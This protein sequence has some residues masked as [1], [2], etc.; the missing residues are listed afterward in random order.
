M[1]RSK[2]KRGQIEK[3]ENWKKTEDNKEKNDIMS[4][5]L[6]RRRIE[7]H[8]MY[9]FRKTRP[10]G[11]FVEGPSVKKLLDMGDMNVKKQKKTVGIRS[12]SSKRGRTV[13]SYGINPDY[14]PSPKKKTCCERLFRWGSKKRNKKCKKKCKTRKR[15]S[16]TLKKKRRRRKKRTRKR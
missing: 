4:A 11:R 12:K 7:E 3:V 14:T 2:S 8:S 9:G 15:K 10:N 13:L 1:P 5:P 16:K 6:S